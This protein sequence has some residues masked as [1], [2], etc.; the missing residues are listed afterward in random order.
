[1]LV[2]LPLILVIWHFTSDVYN[3]SAVY[4]NAEYGFTMRYP[5][6]WEIVSHAEAVEAA[7][8]AYDRPELDEDEG[9]P[10]A[11]FMLSPDRGELFRQSVIVSVFPLE[12]GQVIGQAMLDDFL[13]N[14]DEAGTN[15]GM[16]SQSVDTLAGHKAMRASYKVRGHWR[17]TTYY[18]RYNTYLIPYRQQLYAITCT[19]ALLD[20]ARLEPLFRL[21]FDGFA[22]VES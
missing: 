22:F 17:S 8:K 5:R 14:I 10:P 3:V 7:R 12:A 9:T 19:S 13:S 20:F 6:S 18:I 2:G 4:H 16:I 15:F 21:I 1:M 11:A